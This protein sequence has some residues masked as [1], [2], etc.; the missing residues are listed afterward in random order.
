MSCI[1]TIALF[2]GSV[3]AT[4]M[5]RTKPA[6]DAQGAMQD[7]LM[8]VELKTGHSQNPSHNHL[9]QLST[10]TV[11]L[12]ARHGSARSGGVDHRNSSSLEGSDA[13]GS[14]SSGMLLYLNHQN[15]VAKHIK[16][17]LSDIKTL[18]GQRN[19]V[20]CDV[21][22]AERPRGIA[23]GYE[24]DKGRMNAIGDGQGK[25]IVNE[26]PHSAL[27]SLQQNAGSCERC[28]KNREVSVSLH[29]SCLY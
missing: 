27:P 25:L 19:G 5:S 29:L 21:L 8:P 20:V 14:A 9:A 23:I 24:E 10:Y 12:R 11:M 18:I 22:R 16:P 28:Y 4:V 26:P 1:R 2:R 6:K 13:M 17:S 3:D 15:F 7:A